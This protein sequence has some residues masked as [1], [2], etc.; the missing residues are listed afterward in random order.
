MKRTFLLL[1]ALF[2]SLSYPVKLEARI[3][4]DTELETIKHDVRSLNLINGLY[5]LKKTASTVFIYTV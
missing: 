4:Y 5:F 3:N 1:I 2:L